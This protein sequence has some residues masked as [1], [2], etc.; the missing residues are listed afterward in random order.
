MRLAYLDP[1]TGS[2]I[3]QAVVAGAAGAAVVAKVGWRRMTR[4]FRRHAEPAPE[5]PVATPTETAE[6]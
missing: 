3:T 4:P 1:G 5:Q 2:M 6:H